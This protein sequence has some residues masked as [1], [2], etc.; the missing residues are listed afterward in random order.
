M[1]SRRMPIAADFTDIALP[2]EE[3]DFAV[4]LA[5]T[6]RGVVR[7]RSGQTDISKRKINAQ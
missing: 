3:H 2:T 4:S 1:T 7:F 6:E 5:V